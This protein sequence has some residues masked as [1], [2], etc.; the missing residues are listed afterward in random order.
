MTQ[1]SEKAF[2]THIEQILTEG[3]WLPGTI[4]EWDKA[5]ALFPARV[6]AFIEAT[7]PKLWAELATQHG[8][9]LQTMLGSSQKTEN[10]AR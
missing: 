4:A 7:Q 9:N 3:G 10:K 5:R 2:E 6:F 1:T 8:S